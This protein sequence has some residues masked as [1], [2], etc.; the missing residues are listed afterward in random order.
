MAR[1]LLCF[2]GRRRKIG[3]G[4]CCA[5][6]HDEATPHD[7]RH[8]HCETMWIDT[9]SKATLGSVVVRPELEAD[10]VCAPS[11]AKGAER[12]ELDRTHGLGPAAMG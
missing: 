3:A 6:A 1:I 2:Q 9:H 5:G 10:G 4:G 12:R 8:A 7:E 11:S